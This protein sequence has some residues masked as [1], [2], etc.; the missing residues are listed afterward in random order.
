M[1][2][3]MMVHL[4]RRKPA[5]EGGVALVEFALVLPLILLLLL[6][7]IDV[8]K[9]LNYWN[10]ETHLANEAA[11]AAAVNRSPVAG[12]TINQAVRDEADSAELR[13]GGTSSI[14]SPGVTICIWFPANND[15]SDIPDLP[16][17]AKGDPV[18]V[19]VS[20]RYNWL[21]YLVGRG[22]SAHSTITATSRMRLEKPFKTGVTDTNDYTTGTN[23]ATNDASGT[24]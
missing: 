11:R 2:R 24:C 9:A 6:G 23:T 14:S 21:A 13:N 3:R 17:H 5:N 10:D 4:R 16:D 20:A 1:P 12:Q 7:M 22:V 18:E 8:G 19:K 15:H